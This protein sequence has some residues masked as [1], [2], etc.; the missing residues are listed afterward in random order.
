MAATAP[1]PQHQWVPLYVFHRTSQG[2]RRQA[3]ESEYPSHANDIHPP[4]R[5]PR[6]SHCPHHHATSMLSC[7]SPATDPHPATPT[8]PHSQLNFRMKHADLDSQPEHWQTSTSWQ[9]HFGDSPALQNKQINCTC[10]GIQCL[11]LRPVCSISNE[12]PHATLPYDP[13]PQTVQSIIHEMNQTA[14]AKSWPK[15]SF[16]S[17][18][19]T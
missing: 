6:I 19:T 5:P 13:T 10:V 14:Q 15:N 1:H 17:G 2:G 12:T 16:S 18:P 3:E 4:N 9:N 7:P 8:S 11:K